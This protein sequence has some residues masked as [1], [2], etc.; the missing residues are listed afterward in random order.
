MTCPLTKTA[1]CSEKSELP[2]ACREQADRRKALVL[3]SSARNAKKKGTDS[4]V[5]PAM[6]IVALVIAI[7]I[8]LFCIIVLKLNASI[9]MVLASLFMG[10][11]PAVST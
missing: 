1:T 5:S 10:V 2:E 11:W 6:L 9:G 8:I 3:N 4:M 7:A